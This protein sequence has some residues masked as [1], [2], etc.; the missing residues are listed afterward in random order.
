MSTSIPSSAP[1]A[2]RRPTAWSPESGV[3]GTAVFLTMIVG[4]LIRLVLAAWSSDGLG[5]VILAG[6]ATM[7]MVA[8]LHSLS[9]MIFGETCRS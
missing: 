2:E 8:S 9:E 1:S 4:L 6:T 5:L 7:L 3:L